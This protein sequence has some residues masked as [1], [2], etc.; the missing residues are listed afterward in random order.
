MNDSDP[1]YETKL[2]KLQLMLYLIPVVGWIPA[3]WTLYHHQGNSAQKSVNRISVTLTLSWAIAYILLWT[4]SSFTPETYTLRLLYF[5]GL[6]T[7]GYIVV[8]LGLI[9]RLWRRKYR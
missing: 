9:L 2:N 4:S 7:S 6:L 5:N 1:F 8:S 3:M